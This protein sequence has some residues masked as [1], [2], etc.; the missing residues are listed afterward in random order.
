MLDLR[1]QIL[2]SLPVPRRMWRGVDVIAGCPKGH[3][4]PISHWTGR[5]YM[6]IFRRAKSHSSGTGERV[7]GDTA[8]ALGSPC[9]ARAT[10]LQ[11]S[12][13]THSA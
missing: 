6:S 7:A 13:T 2:V 10:A 1:D 4:G 12:P 9:S 5:R 11:S 8:T 3:R